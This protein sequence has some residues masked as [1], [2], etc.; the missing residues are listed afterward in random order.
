MTGVAIVGVHR[1]GTSA[2]AKVV[3]S[4]GAFMGDDLYPPSQFNPQGYY[5]DKEIVAAHNTLM[6]NDWTNPSV[7]YYSKD[8]YKEYIGVLEKFTAHDFWAIKDPRLCLCLPFLMQILPETKVIAVYRD[9]WY[10]ASSLSQREGFSLSVGLDITLRYLSKMIV[11][12]DSVDKLRIRYTDAIVSTDAAVNK[13]AEFLGVDTTPEAFTAIDKSL[14]HW[15]WL[16]A[17]N[18]I[19]TGSKKW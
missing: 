19:G 10:A 18:I 14:A 5:E 1:G 12:T 3:H 15:E 16:D 7:N 4:L 6:N 13:I 2:I 9:P 11:N 8:E 17:Y